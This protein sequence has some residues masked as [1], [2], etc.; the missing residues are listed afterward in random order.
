MHF[1]Q[2]KNIA[3]WFK[4]HWNISQGCS[5]KWAN[6]D[7]DNGLVPNRQQAIIWSNDGP[8]D[9]EYMHMNVL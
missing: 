4:F 2:T 5:W 6:I 8:V 7:S 9:D 1:Y 3:F